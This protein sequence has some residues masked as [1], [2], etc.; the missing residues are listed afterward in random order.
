MHSR[1]R[2]PSP[3]R[4]TY[5]ECVPSALTT[6]QN[7]RLLQ[8]PRFAVISDTLR[9]GGNQGLAGRAFMLTHEAALRKNAKPPAN[10]SVLPSPGIM[11][12]PGGATI[13]PLEMDLVVG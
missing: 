10:I 9:W 7:R 11:M 4:A 12:F 6:S 2:R 5:N 13:K 3:G 8:P 1:E